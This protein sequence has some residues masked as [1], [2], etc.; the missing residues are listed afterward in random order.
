MTGSKQINT[1]MP[2]EDAER[3]SNSRNDRPESQ[4]SRNDGAAEGNESLMDTV[5]DPDVDTNLAEEI[6]EKGEPFRG[7]HA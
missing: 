5:T 4:S 3:A 1:E 6:E 7:N 2:V